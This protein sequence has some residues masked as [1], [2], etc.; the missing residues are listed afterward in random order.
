MPSTCEST[1]QYC[2]PS[3]AT[4]IAAGAGAAGGGDAAAVPPTA[5]AAAAAG[6]GAATPG[7]GCAAGCM[8]EWRVL[9][10]YQKKRTPSTPDYVC[11]KVNLNTALE[12]VPLRPFRVANHQLS[13]LIF[14]HLIRLRHPVAGSSALCGSIPPSLT[15]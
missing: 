8:V 6:A 14:S 13:R 15:S 4:R 3:T 1:T 7:A 11:A 10:D 12:G 5:A 2:P 9:C